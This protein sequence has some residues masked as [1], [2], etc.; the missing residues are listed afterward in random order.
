MLYSVC[1]I[2]NFLW[3]TFLQ[4][5]SLV[6][7]I[8]EIVIEVLTILVY[9]IVFYRY[10]SKRRLR[11]SMA[12]RDKARSDV[13]LAQLKSQSAPNTPGFGPLSAREGGWRAPAGHPMFKGDAE[14]DD[15]VQYA[16]ASPRQF[17]E[18]K[19][20]ALQAPPIKVHQATP[21]MGQDGFEQH[22]T[23]NQHAHMADDEQ[24]YGSV[25][26]PGSY[27]GAPLNSPGFANTHN[28]SSSQGFDFGLDSRVHDR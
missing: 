7:C 13:Y 25:A 9:G 1:S 5:W 20:F 17:T 11:K 10:Y 14:E 24:Q 16:I 4:N 27:S 6:C 3:L 2:N 19:P 12:T 22:A 28:G 26:I 18:P 21:V 8:I 23:I 15:S